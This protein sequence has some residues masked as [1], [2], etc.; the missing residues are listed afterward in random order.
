VELPP[1][2][3]L[4]G[5]GEF[6]KELLDRLFLANKSKPAEFDEMKHISLSREPKMLLAL[7]PRVGSDCRAYNGVCQQAACV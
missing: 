3:V 6:T 5:F 7:F 1:V 2:S 4:S